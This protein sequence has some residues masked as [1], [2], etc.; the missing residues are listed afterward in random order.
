MSDLKKKYAVVTG[1]SSGIGLHI[2]RELAKRQY[3][4]VA[5]S[6]QPELLEHLKTKL[7]QEYPIEVLPLN[8]DLAKS[9]AAEI[10]FGFC[11][12]QKNLDV[13]VLVNNAGMLVYGEITDISIKQ[14]ENILNL[15]MN[16][17]ALLCR[18][19]G[20]VMVKNQKG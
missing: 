20:E 3:S 6:N 9:D 13:E 18:L 16:T 19:F 10:I 5:V 12:K 14:T 17:P 11:Q 1:A 8:C 2:S 7:E 15:H 4:L